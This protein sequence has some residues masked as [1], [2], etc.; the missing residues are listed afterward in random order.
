MGHGNVTLGDGVGMVTV[1]E[2]AF[3]STR[4]RWT[5]LVV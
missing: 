5:R 3:L 2:P 1:Q 4:G